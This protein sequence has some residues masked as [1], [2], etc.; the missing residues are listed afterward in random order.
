M[1]TRAHR[2]RNE[3]LPRAG[4][5]LIIAGVT[6]RRVHVST[7]LRPGEIDLGPSESHHARD[8]L[9][10]AA[11]APVELFDDSGNLAAGEIARCD[12]GGVSV[13]VGDIR[14]AAPDP[15]TADA[16]LGLESGNERPH[17]ERAFPR[18]EVAWLE[19]SAGDKQVV[20]VTRPA[21]V[22]QQRRSATAKR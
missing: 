20:L 5:P 13:R 10:L 4:G 14:H 19:T 6:V 22:A 11:G 9:R 17:F 7:T 12:A 16:V 1:I 3:L 18:L 15:M 2:G 8:V 21:L